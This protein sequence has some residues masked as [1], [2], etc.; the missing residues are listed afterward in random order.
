MLSKSYF[1][2][3]I[4]EDC[5]S[6]F[7]LHQISIFFFR[8]IIS[9]YTVGS[10]CGWSDIFWFNTYPAP[11]EKWSPSF[12]VY[13]DMGNKNAVSL[14][15]LQRDTQSGMYDMI[16]HVGD[17]AYDMNNVSK[18]LASVWLWSF[19]NCGLKLV[20]PCKKCRNQTL[21]VNFKRQELFESL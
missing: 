16:L 4:L 21:K 8:T 15:A 1:L 19:F 12:A 11:L 17:F 18:H 5:F 20:K 2:L 13:G 7:P 3:R 14:P 9:D 6:I 10:A